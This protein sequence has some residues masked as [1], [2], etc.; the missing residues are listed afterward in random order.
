MAEK[1]KIKAFQQILVNPDA[2]EFLNIYTYDSEQPMMLLNIPYINK[3][4][5]KCVS[6]DEYLISDMKINDKI[7][8]LLLDYIIANFGVGNDR[9]FF[10]NVNLRSD[11][12]VTDHCDKVVTQMLFQNDELCSLIKDTNS[13]FSWEL[14]FEP[15]I[16]N[17]F[18]NLSTEIRQT[19]YDKNVL[20]NKTI[21][22]IIPINTIT[23]FGT[24]GFLNKQHFINFNSG[25]ITLSINDSQTFFSLI[26]IAT[27][28]LRCPVSYFV[29]TP[30]VDDIQYYI[31]NGL[32]QLTNSECQQILQDVIRSIKPDINNVKEL[33]TK[34]NK[35]LYKNVMEEIQIGDM[36]IDA[37]SL[38][39]TFWY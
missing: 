13:M 39:F 24:S 31:H 30:D 12:D 10:I 35:S 11:I 9:S 3:L 22:S 37:A 15:L 7:E 18:T 28:L 27:E 29:I 1:K 36:C 6:T 34:N 19:F 20:L 33:K 17:F 5:S 2:S 25:P 14:N 23:Q 21:P 4:T 16:E 38:L 8:D 32:L 26:N